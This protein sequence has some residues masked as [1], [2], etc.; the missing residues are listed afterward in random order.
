MFLQIFEVVRTLNR[1][2][3]RGMINRFGWRRGCVGAVSVHQRKSVAQCHFDILQQL[4]AAMVHS[5][6]NQPWGSVVFTRSGGGGGGGANNW[7]DG[8]VKVAG[9]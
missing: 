5:K 1:E 9:I 6:T 2:N 4:K 7:R 3:S 8:K